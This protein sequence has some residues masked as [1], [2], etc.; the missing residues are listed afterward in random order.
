MIYVRGI[1]ASDKM[2]STSLQSPI[3]HVDTEI[4]RRAKRVFM[5]FF[6]FY[7]KK[8]NIFMAKELP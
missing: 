5:E 2:L 8:Q 7:F 4:V 1:Y 3:L 6:F